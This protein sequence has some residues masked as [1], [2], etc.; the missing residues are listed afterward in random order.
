MHRCEPQ[1]SIAERGREIGRVEELRR[2]GNVDV[3]VPV[4]VRPP[5]RG[6]DAVDLLE[7]AVP[8]VEPEPVDPARIANRD[9][10]TTDGEIEAASCVLGL[11]KSGRGEKPGEDKSGDEVPAGASEE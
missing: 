1:R 9:A 3:A 5:D 4:A 10:N 6:I 8:V 2:R 11:A 7:P